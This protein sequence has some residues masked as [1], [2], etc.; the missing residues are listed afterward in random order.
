MYFKLFNFLH[1]GTANCTGKLQRAVQANYSELYRQIT[2]SCTGKLHRAV[3]ANYIELYRQ[4]TAS[5]TGKLLAQRVPGG[6]SSQISKQS[7]HEV[8]QPYTP[9]VFT[10]QKIFLV[11]FL[12]ET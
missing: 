10:R 2:A 6:W 5:C 11:T 3:Q 4:I 1:T 8:C 7:A 12:L 9:A